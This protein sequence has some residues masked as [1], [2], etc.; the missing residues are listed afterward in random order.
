MIR[1]IGSALHTKT[2]GRGSCGLGRIGRIAF[3]SDLI[4]RI[5]E[6]R[7]L[8]RLHA[9]DAAQEVGQLRGLHL[10]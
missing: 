5:S 1:G 8:F 3:E 9:G 10:A 4:R 6:I 7:G 2:M